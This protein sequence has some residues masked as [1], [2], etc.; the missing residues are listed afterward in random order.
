MLVN[1]WSYMSIDNRRY[2]KN[3]FAPCKGTGCTSFFPALV[4]IVLA[5]GSAHPS[6]RTSQRCLTVPDV[7]LPFPLQLVPTRC[8]L[9]ASQG[10]DHASDI[11]PI[12]ERSGF[13]NRSPAFGRMAWGALVG[14]STTNWRLSPSVSAAARLTI[15]VLLCLTS[16]GRVNCHRRCFCRARCYATARAHGLWSCSIAV[17]CGSLCCIPWGTMRTDIPSTKI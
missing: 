3:F 1:Y 17:L 16:I 12:Y 15:G 8:T 6:G 4:L 2:I 14:A 13:L 11:F 9:P 10:F 5:L 7:P